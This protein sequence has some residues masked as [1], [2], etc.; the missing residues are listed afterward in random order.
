MTSNVHDEINLK[1]LLRRLEKSTLDSTWA[2]DSED[3]WIEAQGALQ[4]VKYARK[5]LENVELEDVD[6]TP[7]STQRYQDWKAKLSRIDTF[8]QDL[9]KKAA[10]KPVQPIPL[11][12]QIP[13]PPEEPEP[14]PLPTPA[15][16]VP[17]EDTAPATLPT[18]GLLLSV[19]DV[20]PPVDTPQPL[21]SLLPPSYAAATKSTSTAVEPRLLQ[22]STTRQRE[23]ADQ[24]A[25]MAS[26]LKRNAIHFGELMAQDQRVLEETDKKLEG[27]FGYMQQTQVRTKNL[28][29]KSWSSTWIRMLIIFGVVF[30][31]MFMVFFMRLSGR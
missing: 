8:L 30:V 31:F 4:K 15:D 18:D 12:S 26:Q 28:N 2:V 3:T 23:M 21:T 17:G 13:L 16:Q 6:P 20:A 7:K 25:L 14:T 1:R 24:M 27:N 10:P 11:L 22:H 19:A 29:A 5:L 9:E